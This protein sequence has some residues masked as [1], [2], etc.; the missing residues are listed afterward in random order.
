MAR[1]YPDPTRAHQSLFS[2]LCD[3]SESIDENLR[4]NEV[5]IIGYFFP[6]PDG[7]YL[8]KFEFITGETGDSAE[9]KILR[10]YILNYNTAFPGFSPY[11]FHF[12][13]KECNL[14]PQSALEKTARTLAI[15]RGVVEERGFEGTKVSCYLRDIKGK[16]ISLNQLYAL[17]EKYENEKR[18]AE[19]GK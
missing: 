13:E 16:D 4:G 2:L 6:A 5:K 17:L 18:M 14:M 9:D 8:G 7:M 1:E 12:K 11:N 15:L 10:S 3:V 19:Q